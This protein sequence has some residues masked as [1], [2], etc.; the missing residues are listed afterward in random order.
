M[1]RTDSLTRTIYST[2]ASILEL[3]PTAVS[4]PHSIDQLSEALLW[5][6]QRGLS[7][8][9]RGAGTGLAGGALG[10]GLIVDM[11][12]SLNQIIEI[13]PERRIARCQPGLVQDALNQAAAPFGLRLGPD[14]S[15]GDRATIGGMVATNSAGAHSMLYGSMANALIDC[16]LLLANGEQIR[17]SQW[18]R[19]PLD[20]ILARHQEALLSHLP[21]LS[22]RASG[23]NLD[24]LL[25]GGPITDLIAGSEG[26]LGILTEVTLRLEPRLPEIELLILPF[27]TVEEALESVEECLSYLPL[28][29]E[30]IDQTVIKLG[31]LSPSIKGHLGW[32]EGNPGA[33]LV[34]EKELT[35]PLPPLPCRRLSNPI[36][37]EEVWRLRKA[38]L[39]LL[40][41]RRTHSR[42]TAF[43]E[44]LAVAPRDLAPFMRELTKLLS[45]DGLDIGI[46]GHAGPGCLHVRPFLD[47]RHPVEHR[48][49]IEIMRQ[50]CHL[51]GEFR[52][53]LSG[54]HGNGRLRSWLLPDLYGAKVCAAFQEV[55][56][57]FD[58]QG[59]MNPG[60]I[61]ESPPPTSLRAHSVDERPTR[62]SFVREGGFA[63]AAEMCNGNGLCRSRGGLMC[64]SFQ[65]SGDEFDT[66]RARAQAIW[67]GCQGKLDLREMVKVLDRCLECKGCKRECP[68]QVDMAK[69]KV[70]LL[71]RRNQELGPSLRDRLF[72]HAPDLL[73]WSWF[74]LPQGLNQLLG[75]A[76]RPLPRRASQL[77][78]QW[79]A[80]QRGRATGSEVVLLTD[81]YTQHCTPNVGIA[82]FQLLTSL[83]YH[84][85]CPP[86][87]CCGRPLISKGLLDQAAAR[88]RKLI[89]QLLPFATRGIPILTLEPSCLSALIDD[90]LDLVPGEESAIVASSCFPLERFL[91]DKGLALSGPAPLVHT[92]CHDKALS[93]T[94]DLMELLAPLQ[95]ELIPAGCCG[96]AGSFGYEL[97]HYELSMAIAEDRLLPAI[98]SAEGRPIVANGFSCR[99][100]IAQ[101]SGQ[102]A[103][104]PVEFLQTTLKK[105]EK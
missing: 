12:R 87:Q 7:I 42:A 66:T 25:R 75:I 80:E 48:K 81:T 41:S 97:E 14:T 23:Y 61:I 71:Y 59:V 77:F 34:F 53:A 16:Q 9:P 24:W 44:D 2:D 98:R 27:K 50:V 84:P 39:G 6:S 82:A 64:P 20:K 103:L 86:Y 58:P 43:I 1:I 49:M 63:F 30:L 74:S 89:S 15:T 18:D 57:L 46:Y 73:K 60:V 69:L 40:M 17:L 4:T 22:R 54:E 38:G 32:L 96:M 11:A 72:A 33:I 31:R 78:S 35:S 92:H 68:S 70:E 62:L 19:A 101:L 5:A 45:S 29:L 91:K 94:S 104:H 79:V 67:A 28:A 56:Q 51:V 26:T 36:E 88:A 85:F 100:Q 99:T 90:Y 93:P 102:R 10:E 105:V 47:L 8:T 76:P 37:I 13:D 3:L 21:P 55:K 95:P 83:G 52:G 65:G